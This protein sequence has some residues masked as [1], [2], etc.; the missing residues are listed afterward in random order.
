MVQRLLL[1]LL[2]LSLGAAAAEP[3]LCPN[4][5]AEE[6]AGERPAAWTMESG[7]KGL[8]ATDEAHSGRRSLKVVGQRGAT[9]GWLSP[10]IPVDGSRQL[11]LEVWARLEQVTGANGAFVGLYHMDEKGERIG[12]SAMLTLGGAGD[13]VANTDW[14]PYLSISRFGPEVKGVR[15]NLRMYG[16]T[17]TVWFDDVRLTVH[18]T[19]PLD[20]PR[21]LRR[22]LRLS[23]AGGAAIVSAEGAGALT[24]EVQAALRARGQEVPVLAGAEVDLAGEKRDLI[25]LG[26]LITS[27]VA[28][29]L[30]RRSYTLEDAG[31]PGRGGYVLRPLVDPLGTGN[32]LLVVGASD[33]AGLE[34]GVT[35]LVAA[36]RR[37]PGPLDLPL[38]VKHTGSP[39]IGGGW[40]EP[41]VFDYLT[42][43]NLESARSFRESMLRK[44]A[45]PDN[46]LFNR[47]SA[48]HLFFAKEIISWDLMES[49]GV[50]SDAERLAIAR[51]LLKIA[52]SEEGY[53]YPGLRDG[54]T[55]RENHGTRAARAFYYAWR[56][57]SKYHP[58]TLGVELSLWRKKLAGFWAACFASSRTFEDSLSQHALGGS[59][60]N[61]LDIGFQEP[62]WSADFFA[63]G[64]ARQMGERC[65]AIST[66]MGLTVLLGDTAAGDYAGSVFAMLAYHFRDPRYTFM[67]AK[68]GALGFSTD[69]PLRSFDLGLV[70]VA[71]ADH[72][73]LTIIPADDLYFRTG[74]QRHE[75]VALEQAFDK[76][77][78]RSGFSPDDEYLMLDGIAGGSH[79]YDDANSIGEFA[80]N[81]RRWLCEIDIFNGPTMSFHNA[82]TVARDGLGDPAV[83][84]AAE[85][86]TSAQGEGYAYSATRLP[87]YNHT[88]WTRH[89]LW[90]PGLYTVVLDELTAEVAGDYSLVLGWRSLGQPDLRPGWFESAQDERRR[91]GTILGGEEMVAAVTAHSA[92]TLYHLASYD[93]LF[94]RADRVGD[95]VELPLA[96][97][98]DGSY[99][100][101]LRTVLYSGRSIIQASLDGAPLGPPVDLFLEGSPRFADTALGHHA[102]TGGQHAL[103]F[104]VI[105]RAPASQGYTFAVSELAL[106]RAGEGQPL[107]VVPNRFRLVFPADVSATLD[108]DTETLG[109]YLP[110]SPH[111]DQALNLVEQGLSRTLQAGE[112]ACFQ[113]VFFATRGDAL[114]TVELR[115]LNEHCALLR[116]SESIALVGA[117]VGA[118][119]AELGPLAATGKLFYLSPERVILQ[120]ASATLAGR[121]LTVGENPDRHLQAALEAAWEGA[122]PKPTAAA[123]A[124]SVVPPLTPRWSADLPAKPLSV[125]AYDSVV[126][127]R[128]AVGLES[129]L[130]RQFEA[131][132]EPAGSFTTGGPVHALLGCDLDGVAGQELLVGSDDEFLYALRPDLTEVW[133]YQVPF[134][135]DEQPWEWWTLGRAKVRRL[136]ADDLNGD[137][138]PEI[139]MGNGN[140]RLH[141]FD[142]A[143]KEIWRFRTDHGICTTITA[144]DVFGDGKR[145]VLAGNGL[146]SSAGTCWV[147]DEHGKELQR[148]F[149]GSWCTALPA[150]AVGDLD[151]DGKQTVFCGNNRGDVRAYPGL[152]G[153]VEQ[154][155]IHN[156]TRPIRSL[157]VLPC[158]G[159][160]LLAVGSDSGTLCAFTQTGEKAWGVPLSSA[161]TQTALVTRG[162]GA[163]LLAAGCKDGHIFLV[164]P[165]GKLAASFTAPGRLQGFAVTELDGDGVTDIAVLTAGPDRLYVLG[166]R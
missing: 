74:I 89:L 78:F 100:V 124:A 88:A 54:L 53:G 145:R 84:Q 165:E 9:I 15:V 70:P 4:P 156:L 37:D 149:N 118:A 143:G 106:Q 73:G 144:A 99:D 80:A 47:D 130:V 58:D 103:R 62:E 122:T 152:P 17:G 10:I 131:A 63:S 38:T 13:A 85:V 19:R 91:R 51:Y 164:T 76:L 40:L 113:N 135:R 123:A 111:Y 87:H 110:P 159:G 55:S 128:L 86:V 71:P 5:G 28:E 14:Q 134:L 12:Q 136:Y 158:Q 8:W 129:G 151:G 132:G 42:T 57:F 31:Y 105:G 32:N 52:R 45:V 50:F 22:G 79:S 140:M 161:I 127:L 137:G 2:A 154:L 119:R 67:L 81:H 23:A 115:R 30:Y 95:F 68:R 26:N 6:A 25:V 82:V 163:T 138:R 11:I 61:I 93:A 125:A 44:A 107:R 142:T 65:V 108:R 21:P 3:N 162:G 114:R 56:Y 96:V 69:E 7:A 116:S 60:V 126:G 34:A 157:T 112:S 153:K 36:I 41:G 101:S 160:D 24:A 97:P 27:P 109:K 121:P 104:T 16:A 77:T 33:Q 92:K 64:R 98:A 148:Y 43:G 139:L 141:C 46:T 166:V 39:R 133:R 66:N 147:L 1:S 72:V 20:A 59:M 146:T 35:A 83:P 155:W 117:G 150:I 94:Y 102:L 49:C 120:Q 29:Y 75:G 48:L 90:L 18:A